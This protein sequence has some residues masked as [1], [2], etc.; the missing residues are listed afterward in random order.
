MNHDKLCPCGDTPACASD[1]CE[2]LG[3]YSC[4]CRCE[5]ITAARADEWE[6]AAQRVINVDAVGLCHP[7]AYDKATFVAAARGED[8]S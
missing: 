3:I 4:C 2:E 8:A 7:C 5:E 6:K 1:P